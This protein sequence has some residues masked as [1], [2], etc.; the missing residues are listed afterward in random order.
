ALLFPHAAPPVLMPELPQ[1]PP[2]IT[3]QIGSHPTAAKY[4]YLHTQTPKLKMNATQVF[5][6]PLTIIPDPSTPL[7]HKAALSSQHIHLFLPHHA[8]ITIIQSPRQT[9]PIQ[10]EKITLSVNKYANTS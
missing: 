8:N 7:V 10:R 5:K 3:Y 6:F 9:L 1:P 2:I 4:F